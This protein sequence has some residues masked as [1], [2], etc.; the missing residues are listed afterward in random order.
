MSIQSAITG[1]QLLDIEYYSIQKNK[2]Q[3]TIEPFVIYSTQSNWLL[4]AYCRLRDEFRAF[5]I[6]LIQTLLVKEQ[7]FAPHNITLEQYFELCRQKHKNTPDIP[8]S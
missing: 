7:T 5:R 3:R 4:I 6:D 1:F 8:L 2:T